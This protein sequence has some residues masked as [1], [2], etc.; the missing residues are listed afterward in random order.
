MRAHP[1]ARNIQPRVALPPI[2]LAPRDAPPSLHLAR[3]PLRLHA[4]II[5][6]RRHSSS[7]YR[8]V[9]TRPN[10]TFYTEIRSGEERIELGTF[11]TVHETACAYDAV[12][13]RL[14]RSRR[15]MNFDETRQQ[16]EALAPPPAVTCEVRQR[17]R[18]LEQRL[19]VAERDEHMRLEWAQRFPE[20]V[21]VE[22]AFC[23]EKEEAKVAQ[24]AVKK[25]DREPA[26]L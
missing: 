2:H 21:A 14:G 25:R 4:A 23:A 19:V 20:D 15:S 11:E 16:E 6:P 18:E 1:T 24:K 22:V 26:T 3:A 5:P 8:G 9:R 13:W 10:G 17:H 7:G 12:A